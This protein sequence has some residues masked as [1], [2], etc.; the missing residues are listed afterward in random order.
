MDGTGKG[1]EGGTRCWPKEGLCGGG[2]SCEVNPWVDGRGEGG[3][4]P[5]KDDV[6]EGVYSGGGTKDA[7]ALTVPPPPSVSIAACKS[8]PY[9]SWNDLRWLISMAIALRS[10]E[11]RLRFCEIAWLGDD[12]E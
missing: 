2:A 5:E 7:L 1:G 12:E 8:P 11:M 9:L 10:A 3:R 4:E 6:G